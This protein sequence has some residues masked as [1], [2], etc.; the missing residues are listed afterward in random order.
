MQLIVW[1]SVGGVETGFQAGV[2][3]FVVFVVALLLVLWAILNFWG[4]EGLLGTARLIL[5]IEPAY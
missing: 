4:Q 5:W 3:N 1:V 2:S